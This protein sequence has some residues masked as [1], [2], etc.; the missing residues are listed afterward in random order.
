MSFCTFF[1]PMDPDSES[2]PG[3]S[4]LLDSKKGTKWQKTMCCGA[5]AKI[6]DKSGAKK[7]LEQKKIILARQHWKNLNIFLLFIDL[8]TIFTFTYWAVVE[9]VDLLLFHYCK[10][11]DAGPPWCS[12][13]PLDVWPWHRR[14]NQG[15][16]PRSFPFRR[17]RSF[18]FKKENVTFFSVLF[19]S[20]WRLMKPTRTLRSFLLFSKERKRT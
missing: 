4:G 1:K 20:F 17:F 2:I 3:F 5:G 15:W 13:S 8:C 11:R 12:P 9:E 7:D 6:L 14:E 19:S 10:P 16:A 18:P